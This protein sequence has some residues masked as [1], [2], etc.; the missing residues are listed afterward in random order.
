LQQA[1]LA[2]ASSGSEANG[3]IGQ[4]RGLTQNQKQDLLNFLRSL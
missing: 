1:I 4:F 3:V 2:H